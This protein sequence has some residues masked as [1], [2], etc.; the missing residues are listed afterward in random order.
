MSYGL[1]RFTAIV[2]AGAV[3]L[4]GLPLIAGTGA[5]EARAGGLE[6]RQFDPPAR[7]NEPPKEGG[8]IQQ[9]HPNTQDNVSQHIETDFPTMDLNSDMTTDEDETGRVTFT[10]TQFA[11]HAGY[12][13]RPPNWHGR[14]SLNDV[15]GYSAGTATIPMVAEGDCDGQISCTYTTGEYYLAPGWYHAADQNK[16]LLSQELCAPS[17]RCTSTSS[18]AAVYIPREEDLEDPNLWMNTTGRGLTTKAVATAEDPEGKSM[19]LRWDFGDGTSQP[20]QFGMVA[21][22][23]Y[24]RPGTYFVTARVTTSDGRYAVESSSAGVGVPRPVIQTVARKPGTTEAAVIASLPGWAPG[25]RAFARYWTDG[26]PS[27]TVDDD[28]YYTGSSTNGSVARGDR[29]VT[30]PVRDLP[31]AA[32]AF[33]MEAEG[34]LNFEGGQSAQLIRRSTCVEMSDLQQMVPTTGATEVGATTVPI[35]SSTVPVGNVAVIDAT[36]YWGAQSFT[37]QRVVKAHGSLIVNALDDPH[38]AG[39]FVADAG[40]PVKPYKPAGPPADPEVPSEGDPV[41]TPPKK[42]VITNVVPK[43]LNHKAIISFR[44]RANGGAPILTYQAKCVPVSAG[45][46][47]SALG[48]ASP[49]TVTNLT[50]DKRYQCQ[51]RAKNK[52]GFGV[53]SDKSAIFKAI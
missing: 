33:A 41:I 11:A 42:P 47:R 26:C 44:P 8:C 5:G 4:L 48:K 19:K 20:G 16:T 7:C 18:E 50:K 22:H 49:V 37:E 53:W 39:A 17:G 46:A 29:T 45:Q 3:A 52:V 24:Q 38:P 10:I 34:Y 6:S 12:A 1:S 28:T 30:M 32:N 2:V 51:V 15:I 31:E 43:A 35:A 25:A 23:T 9:P 21:A 14:M 36:N 40:A 27:E 13:T